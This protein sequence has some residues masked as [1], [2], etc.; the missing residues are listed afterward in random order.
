MHDP[1]LDESLKRLAAE[2]STRF[3]SL[4]ATGDEIPFDVA[5]NNGDSSHFYRYVPLTSRYIAAHIGELKSLPSYGPARGAVASSQVAAPYLESR[6][7]PVPSDPDRRAEEMLNVFIGSLWEG[8]TEF[9]LDISRVEAALESLEVEARDVHEADVLLVPLVGFEMSP[10]EIELS[11]GLKIVRADSIDAPLEAI[12]SEGTDRSAWQPAF[13]AM[14]PLGEASEGPKAAIEKLHGLVR[15]LRL[16]KEGTVGLGP[17]AFAPVGDD[18]WRRVETGAAPPRQG[19]YFLIESEVKS[20]DEF[21]QKLVEDSPRNE[22]I[23]F[24]EKRFQFG[25]ERSRPVDALPDHLLAIRSA[26]GGEGVIDAPLAARAA[27]LI[28]GKAEDEATR[29]RIETALDLE[30]ALI[31]NEETTMIGGESSSYLSAWVED[32]TRTILREAVL[33]KYE[34]NL[35]IVAEET[36][37]TSGLQAGEGSI[38]QR[39][40]TTEWDTIPVPVFEPSDGEAPSPATAE[41]HV[42]KPRVV[43]NFGPEVEAGFD[44]LFGSVPEFEPA[45]IPGE[46]KAFEPMPEIEAALGIEPGSNDSGSAE[47]GSTRLLEPVPEPGEIT[48]SARDEIGSTLREDWL[49]QERTGDTLSWPSHAMDGLEAD[50]R[51]RHPSPNPKFFPQPETTEWSVSELEY[52]RNRP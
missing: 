36:L 12:S 3:T 40:D 14:V 18:A 22:A 7:I 32:S 30:Q 5:E 33:G 9:S 39:G 46:V 44:P 41:I 43:E 45:E 38:R 52:R 17:F 27:A 23:A 20:L 37:I 19:S 51:Q 4:V 11:N 42:F 1:V 47:P 10:S 34:T 25:C 13:L 35:N 50:R 31:N 24:A 28:S 49:E 15:A 29:R 6:G 8:T 16:F 48:V 21:A 26:L 2:A